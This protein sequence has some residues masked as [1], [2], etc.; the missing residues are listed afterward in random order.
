LDSLNQAS[1]QPER[2]AQCGF[3]ARHFTIIALVVK[4]RQMKDSV[5]RQNLDFLGGGMSEPGRIL[6]CNVGGDGDFA[7]QLGPL[8]GFRSG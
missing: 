5:Q 4:A 1:R 8:A 6:Q 3:L 2:P 7:R